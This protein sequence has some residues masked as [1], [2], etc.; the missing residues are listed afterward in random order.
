MHTYTLPRGLRRAPLIGI[1]LVLMLMFGFAIVNP[2]IA[3][4]DTTAECGYSDQ[5]IDKIETV[6]HD[7]GSFKIK[8]TPTN[9]LRRIG[10]IDFT[11]GDNSAT[12]SMWHAV[13]SCVPGLYR[14]LADSVWQQLQCHVWL[15]AAPNKYLNGWATGSTFDLES[16]RY[17]DGTNRY[18]LL[19]PGLESYS[20]THCLNEDS[21]NSGNNARY[22]YAPDPVYSN[23]A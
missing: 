11:S 22:Y 2:G 4:A 14:D 12:I 1:V 9:L 20:A 7:D 23:Y 10:W 5:Y 21:V 15:S 16:L 17:E 8:V 6:Y 3:K 18:P 19:H 13:Q